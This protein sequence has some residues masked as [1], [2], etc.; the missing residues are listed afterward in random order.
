MRYRET[1]R[2]REKKRKWKI[3]EGKRSTKWK[4]EVRESGIWRERERLQEKFRGR[5]AETARYFCEVWR[6]REGKIK[7]WR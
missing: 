3:D 7:N 1:E 4:I 6:Q 5:L 2:E